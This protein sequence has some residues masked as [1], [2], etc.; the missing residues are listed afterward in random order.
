MAELVGILSISVS[1]SYTIIIHEI[2]R[3]KHIKTYGFIHEDDIL[4]NH[5]GEVKKI[6]L[7]KLMG[8]SPIMEVFESYSP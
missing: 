4:N 3:L 2:M 8:V 6:R 7:K 1:K 5:S